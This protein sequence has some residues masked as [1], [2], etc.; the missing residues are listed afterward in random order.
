M[1]A[2]FRVTK[3]VG[4]LGIV[5]MFG[6]T[7]S[8]SALNIA[9]TKHNLSLANTNLGTAAGELGSTEI[10]VYCHTPHNANGSTTAPLW[11]RVVPVT[12]DFT[13][14]AS[15]VLGMGSL[16][17]LG[18]HD[19]SIALNQFGGAAWSDD[20]NGATADIN[21]SGPALFG[22]DLTNQH[23]IGVTYPVADPTHFNATPASA[24]IL[25]SKVECA[26]CHSPHGTGNSYFLHVENTGS[27]LCLDCHVK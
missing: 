5:A 8:A 9:T 25:D 16:T 3:L 13:L 4:V 17:C 18:C 22:T 26:S 14:R 7:G 6:M 15:A 1:F 20:N 2:S 27:A 10:C 21:M 11:N 24:E 12:G 19:G 23:P